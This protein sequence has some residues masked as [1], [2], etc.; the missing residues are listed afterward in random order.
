MNENNDFV[1]AVLHKSVLIYSV[2]F[3]GLPQNHKKATSISKQTYVKQLIRSHYSLSDN[4]SAC[5]LSVHNF[6]KRRQSLNRNEDIQVLW[7]Y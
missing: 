5:L 6:I 4:Y 7:F 1:T 2:A 3:Y